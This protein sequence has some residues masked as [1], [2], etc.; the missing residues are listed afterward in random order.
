VRAVLFSQSH[1]DTLAPAFSNTCSTKDVA[2]LVNHAHD[3][4]RCSVAR[5]IFELS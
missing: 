4:V 3:P 1:A 2:A 5:Q